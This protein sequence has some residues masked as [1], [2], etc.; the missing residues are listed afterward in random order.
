MQMSDVQTE[1]VVEQVDDVIEESNE[2]GEQTAIDPI[3]QKA[4]DMGWRPKEDFQGEE[5]DFIDA[6]E[7]VRRKPLFDKIEVQKRE[8]KE[9][10]KALKLLQSHHEGVKIAEY[11]RAVED[12]KAEKK[13]ALEAGDADRLIEIDDQI[14]DIKADERFAQQEA[15]KPTVDPRFVEWVA[16]NSWYTK[17]DELRAVADEVG[18]AHSKLHPEKAPDEVLEYVVKR[19]KKLYPE[20]FTNPNKNRPSSVEGGSSTPSRTTK[21][22]DDFELDDNERKMMN[23]FIRDKIMT[24]EQYISDLKKIKGVR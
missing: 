19:V 17:N 18:L 23:T 2:Q 9:V 22:S 8:L 24:K 20:E 10:Q 3:E 1:E 15:K 14:A 13:V 11:K 12:L 21:S 7:F 5:G 6:K 16:E 4:L